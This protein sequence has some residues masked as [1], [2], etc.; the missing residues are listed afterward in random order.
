MKRTGFVP[1][2]AVFGAATDVCDANDGIHV[3]H[4]HSS[5]RAEGWFHVD[6]EASIAVEQRTS[7]SG[8][9]L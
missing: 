1:I 8:P 3:V 5:E 9:G 2:L 7:F 6:A 4:E